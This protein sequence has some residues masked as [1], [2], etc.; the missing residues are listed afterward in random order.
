[1]SSHLASLFWAAAIVVF[2]RS[3]A[4]PR[5]NGFPIPPPNSPNKKYAAWATI[6]TFRFSRKRPNN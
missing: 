2:S 6:F 3:F 1:L 4:K 5:R